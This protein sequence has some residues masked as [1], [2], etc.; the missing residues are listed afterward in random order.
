V[1]GGTGARARAI[2]ND[3]LLLQWI[4]T[5][6]AEGR[7]FFTTHALTKHPAV[8]GFTARHAIEALRR[9]TII[10]RRDDESRCVVCGEAEGVR[11][12]PAYLARYIHCVVQWD[13]VTRVVIIT[14]YRPKASEWKNPFTRR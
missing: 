3:E 7:Y 10:S 14:M 2:I 4:A 6:V 5:C 11:L 8:E 9:G 12:D 1:R 13:N